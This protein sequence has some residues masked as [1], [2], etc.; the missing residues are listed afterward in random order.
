M[1]VMRISLGVVSVLGT[2]ASLYGGNYSAACFAAALGFCAIDLHLKDLQNRELLARNGHLRDALREKEGRA[3]MCE[4]CGYYH[5]IE[6]CGY[7]DACLRFQ[8]WVS[9]HDY[10]LGVR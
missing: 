7:P 6:L 8:N 1:T 9:K 3:V 5:P 2:A 10:E 4:T